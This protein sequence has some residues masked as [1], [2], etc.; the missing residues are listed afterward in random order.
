M[1]N[2]FE[3]E[4][5]MEERLKYICGLANDW[6]RFAEAKNAA[7]VAA[8][9]ALIVVGCD[10]FPSS[11][12]FGLVQWACFGGCVLLVIAGTLSL[13]SFIPKLTFEWT[14]SKAEADAK[15]NLFFFEHIAGYSA[16]DFLDAL[17]QAELAE[18]PKRKLELDLAG[19]AVIN[20]QIASRKFKQFR[21]ACW[22]ALTGLILLGVSAC[23]QIFK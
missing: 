15:H 9:C 14:R 5:D 22:F 1:K 12:K 6:L 16:F 10:H 13:A 20:S 8:V 21:T 11:T 18:S 7:M 4:G 2:T 3:N 19:Q 23:L 17:Y